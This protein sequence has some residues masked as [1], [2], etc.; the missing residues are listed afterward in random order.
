MADHS[1]LGRKASFFFA[2]LSDLSC[3]ITDGAADPEMCSEIESAGTEVL[4]AS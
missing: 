4:V 1:K 3:V 2:E